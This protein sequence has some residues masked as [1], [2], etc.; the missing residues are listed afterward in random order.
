MLATNLHADD[1][2]QARDQVCVDNGV[3]LEH[4]NRFE[5]LIFLRFRG[6]YLKSRRWIEKV[7]SSD[8]L[9]DHVLVFDA[10]NNKKIDSNLNNYPVE[11]DYIAAYRDFLKKMA[12]K[13]RTIEQTR[14]R[15]IEFLDHNYS[16]RR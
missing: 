13:T 9:S 4:F 6:S 1:L 10:G 14:Q 16:I 5:L 15:V 7:Y 3:P 12:P 8:A 2:E 11:P